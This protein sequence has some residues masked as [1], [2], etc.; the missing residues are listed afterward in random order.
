VGISCKIK[1]FRKDEGIIRHC[2]KD[3]D[4][5]QCY[6]HIAA[7]KKISYLDKKIHSLNN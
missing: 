2:V 4:V 3:E 6:S 5:I 1:Q 7:L